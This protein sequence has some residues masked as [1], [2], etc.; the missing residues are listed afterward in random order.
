[1]AA[2]QDTGLLAQHLD[3]L[4]DHLTLIHLAGIL[5]RQ[6]RLLATK[7]PNTQH[8]SCHARTVVRPGLCNVLPKS[9]RHHNADITPP[10][11]RPGRQRQTDLQVVGRTITIVGDAHGVVERPGRVGLLRPGVVVVGSAV[12][13]V[14]V[15]GRNG[16]DP[17][18]DWSRGFMDL[19]KEKGVEA[20]YFDRFA[21]R[22]P[23]IRPVLVGLQGI[24]LM[25]RSARR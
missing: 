10:L 22:L 5:I 19:A 12:A 6:V 7:K 4:L 21:L 20:V 2:A 9:G 25:L 1:M 8:D 15:G 13:V 3:D 14:G 16:P 11:E 18:L 24:S 23:E 17:K